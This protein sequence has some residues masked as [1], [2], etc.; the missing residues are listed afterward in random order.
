MCLPTEVTSVLLD[1]TA[2]WDHLSQQLV[3]WEDTQ[4]TL[5]SRMKS[6]ASNA[7]STSTR[8]SQA[9]KAAKSVVPPLSPTVEQ[10]PVLALASAATS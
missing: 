1:P 4:S 6:S 10:P 7:K 5:A 3:Q 9:N 2:L 8:T